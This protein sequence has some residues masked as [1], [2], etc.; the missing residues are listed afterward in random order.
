MIRHRGCY[1][2]YY[3]FICIRNKVNGALRD[4]IC[5]ISVKFLDIEEHAIRAILQGQHRPKIAKVM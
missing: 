5:D 1:L 2:C 4:A 3:A